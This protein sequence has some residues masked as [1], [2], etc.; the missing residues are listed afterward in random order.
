MRVMLGAAVA[1]SLAFSR[2]ALARKG[3]SYHS[4]TSSSKKSSGPVCKKGKPCGN[5]CIARDNVCHVG[6]GTARSG[7]EQSPPEDGDQ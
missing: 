3:S 6:R 2:P 5:S 4:K 7:E 1:V